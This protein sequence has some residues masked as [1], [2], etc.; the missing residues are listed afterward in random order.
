[1]G[2]VTELSSG[3][4]KTSD[5]RAVKSSVFRAAVVFCLVRQ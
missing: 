2:L 5:E 3:L 4:E 1:M